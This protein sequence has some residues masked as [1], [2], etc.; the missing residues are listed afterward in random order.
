MGIS[1]DDGTVFSAD[2]NKLERI[3]QYL[4][5]VFKITRG[6]MVY[7]IG[8]E[9]YQLSDRSFTLLHQRCY[10]HHRDVCDV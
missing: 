5:E 10:I 9:V 8:L 2:A 4:D 3:L 6:S 7:Y 1:V